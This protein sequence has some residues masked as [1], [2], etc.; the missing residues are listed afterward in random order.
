MWNLK[1]VF[2]GIGVLLAVAK[3]NVVRHDVSNSKGQ[4]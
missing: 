4:I 1:K 2:L 3:A